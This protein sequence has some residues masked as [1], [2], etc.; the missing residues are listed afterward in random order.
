LHRAMAQVAHPIEQD[1]WPRRIVQPT[2][3][4]RYLPCHHVS[5]LI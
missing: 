4:I 2:F 1:Q 3:S 5:V